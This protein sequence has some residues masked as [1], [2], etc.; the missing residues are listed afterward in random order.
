MI[1]TIPDSLLSL[2]SNNC[3]WERL[4]TLS[5]IVPLNPW[6]G[7]CKSVT[8]VVSPTTPVKGVQ[9]TPLHEQ[10]LVTF[11]SQPLG[12]HSRYIS[13][14]ARCCEL[15]KHGSHNPFPAAL[16]HDGRGHVK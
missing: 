14:I 13:I 15:K 16:Q 7:S 3:S 1:G 12:C 5:G 9:V 6:L 4:P 10:M 2:R 11:P 8:L